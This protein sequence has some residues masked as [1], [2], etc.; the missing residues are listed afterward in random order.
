MTNSFIINIKSTCNYAL[1]VYDT[2]I[3]QNYKSEVLLNELTVSIKASIFTVIT[4]S[5]PK[6]S[7]HTLFHMWLQIVLKYIIT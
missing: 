1:V 6:V 2:E 4:H 5:K 7:M 3:D